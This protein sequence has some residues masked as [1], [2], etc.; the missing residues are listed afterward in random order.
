MDKK[1]IHEALDKI[2]D[3]RPFDDVYD[4]ITAYIEANIDDFMECCEV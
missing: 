1:E 2:R 4:K 3:I